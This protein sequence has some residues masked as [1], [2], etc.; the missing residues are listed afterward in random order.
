MTDGTSIAVMREL[1]FLRRWLRDLKQ[2]LEH[3]TDAIV[4][5]I[6]AAGLGR[7]NELRCQLEF[8]DD[9]T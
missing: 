8:G 1:M 3:A 2:Q 6:S 4:E 5:E 9:E 7:L